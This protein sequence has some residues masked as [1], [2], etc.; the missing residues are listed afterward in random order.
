MTT[1]TNE[2]VLF[3][4]VRQMADDVSGLLIALKTRFELIHQIQRER[5]QLGKLSDDALYDLGIDRKD[6]NRESQRSMFSVP[7][8][9][10]V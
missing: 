10:I 6:A 4:Y 3:P 9:R 7:S 8:N 1:I 2:K 5:L